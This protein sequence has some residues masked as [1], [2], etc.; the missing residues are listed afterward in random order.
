LVRLRKR[1]DKAMKRVALA[2]MAAALAGAFGAAGALAQDKP[3]VG[4]RIG[5]W[6]FQC[7]ALTASET[8]CALIQNIVNNQSRQ[9]VIGA[10]LRKLGPKGDKLGLFIAAPLGIFLGAGIAPKIDE[11]EQFPLVLQNCTAQNGCRAALEIDAKRL[12]EMK[13]GNRLLIGFKTRA[14]ANTVTVPVSLKGVTDGL[15]ALDSK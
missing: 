6:V 14:D 15:K 10:V 9:R 2:V 13:K 8:R 4:D 3:K 7:Q 5:D 1:K 11:G 12:A